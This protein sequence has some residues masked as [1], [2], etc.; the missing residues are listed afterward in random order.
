M[1]LN[2]VG[3]RHDMTA[4][5]KATLSTEWRRGAHIRTV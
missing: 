3:I 2:W 4:M 5:E 1:D